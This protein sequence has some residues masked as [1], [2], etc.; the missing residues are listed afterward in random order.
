MQSSSLEAV[1]NDMKALVKDAQ[2]LFR[3]AGA[4]TGERADEL[5]SKGLVLLD[6]A[7]AKAQEVQS[8]AIETGKEIAGSA[9]DF[10]HEK[11][12]QAVAISAGVGLLVG[13]LIARK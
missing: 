11:P 8:V 6:V 3:Q 2:D 1:R 5:R 10:V 13:L 7:M 12:W 9:D 4:A